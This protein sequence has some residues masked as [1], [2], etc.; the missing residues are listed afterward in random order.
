MSESI[1][2][3]ISR[4]LQE[5]IDVNDSCELTRVIDKENDSLNLL[6]SIK[7]H[8]EKQGILTILFQIQ[9]GKELS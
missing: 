2:E 1:E 9:K 6:K 3:I 5:G 4:S 7:D 8:L